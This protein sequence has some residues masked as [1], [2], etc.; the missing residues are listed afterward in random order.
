MTKIMFNVIP[1]IFQGVEI[2]VFNF[3]FG[4]GQSHEI[5]KCFISVG[6]TKF[7]YFNDAI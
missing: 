6:Y 1:V 4:S 3:P 7:K 5:F 2:F